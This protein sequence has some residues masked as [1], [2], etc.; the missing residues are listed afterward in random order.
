MLYKCFYYWQR[1]ATGRPPQQQITASQLAAALAAATASAAAHPSTSASSSSVSR[2]SSLTFSIL[3]WYMCDF[4]VSQLVVCYLFSCKSTTAHPSST[5][6]SSSSVSRVS[7]LTLSLPQPVKF[8][9][10]KM[11]GRTCK[12][13]IFQSCNTSTFN[14]MKSDE[15]PFTCQCKKEDKK[16]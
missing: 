13:Y 5:S 11:H 9:G 6:A 10:W 7:S 4:P 15:N 8:L 14:A 16:A 2:V 3:N 12:Q 1:G